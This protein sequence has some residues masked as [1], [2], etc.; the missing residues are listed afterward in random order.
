MKIETLYYNEWLSLKKLTNGKRKPYIFSHETRCEGRVI[1]ILPYKIKNDKLQFLLRNEITPCW[2][3]ESI[4]CSITGGYEGGDPRETAMLELKEEAGYVIELENII[5]LDTCFG[6]KSSD[7]I[8]HL[9]S[10]NL[11]NYKQ[12]QHIVDKSKAYS[13]WFDESIISSI[14]DPFAA[15]IYLRLKIFLNNH[16]I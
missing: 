13:A 15:V 6:T 16:D 11:T 10:I 2:S 1:S 3:Q 4:L 5:N 12:Q 7:S 14:K 8:Y 9:Y